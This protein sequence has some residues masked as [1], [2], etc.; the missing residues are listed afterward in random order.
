MV[1]E[2]ETAWEKFLPGKYIYNTFFLV[3][4]KTNNQKVICITFYSSSQERGVRVHCGP[5]PAAEVPPGPPGSPS[6]SLTLHHQ[7]HLHSRQLPPHSCQIVNAKFLL[8]I[9]FHLKN[10]SEINYSLKIYK[11]LSPR[12]NDDSCKQ[13][14]AQPSRTPSS[15]AT[16]DGPPSCSPL[17]RHSTAGCS[18]ACSLLNPRS[19]RAL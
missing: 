3:N 5:A 13:L 11:I 9:Y 12:N 17:G 10:L 6:T 18:S 4:K 1:S 15:G 2:G 7:P 14:K 8:K 16:P 19:S